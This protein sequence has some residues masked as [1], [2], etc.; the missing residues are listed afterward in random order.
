VLAWFWPQGAILTLIVA[1]AALAYGWGMSHDALEPYY[2]ASVRSMSSN[3]HDFLY[4]A[5]DPAGTLTL[6]KL[7][8][9][10]W[11]QA[12]FVAL[13]G[14]HTWAMVLPQAIEGVLTV[15]FLYRAVARLA[16]RSAGLVAA[17]VLAASPAVVALDRG[18]IGDSLMILLLVLAA[19][20]TSAA[21]VSG[22]SRSLV[23]AGVWV[24]LAFQAKMIQAWL[25]LPALALAYLISGPGA[26]S[27]RW[28]QVGVAG[29]V[30]GAV[31]VSWMA[32]VSVTP[33][34]Y[35]PYV[36]GSTNDSWFQQVF[37][38]NGLNRL[39]GE[40]PLQTLAGQNIGTS[41][42]TV[43][44][45]SPWRLLSGYL[46]LDT[47]W[48]LL[49]A[50]VVAAASFVALRRAPRMDPRRASLILWVSWLVVIGAAFS[51]GTSINP[52]YTAALAPAV[53]AIL[54]IGVGIAWSTRSRFVPLVAGVVVIVSVAYAVWLLPSMASRSPSWLRPAA[55][56]VGVAGLGLVAFAW[57]GR[58]RGILAAGLVASLVATCFAPTVAAVSIV[59]SHQ[60][61]FD[62]P[63]EPGSASAAI[64][65]SFIALP[66]SIA[67]TVPRLEQVRYGAP[68]LLATQTA[69]IAS[70]FIN[71]TGEEAL[72]IGGF[73]GTAP[74][75]TLADIKSDVCHGLFHLVLITD[76]S[77]PRFRWIADNCQLVGTDANGV[78]S[79]FCVPGA[80]C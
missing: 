49:A 13:F 75:P 30:T 7:P 65:N 58:R 69:V 3:A 46:G 77:D 4:G 22:R 23:L 26:A 62:T 31:S 78:E 15:V 24:G 21:V 36:D 39:G 5:V 54:G 60:G 9:A 79:Y 51:A 45:A 48:L 47:G 42:V 6:D 73:S 40:T 28:R 74:T 66:A 8:G 2:E 41:L 71:A 33:A 57:L 14:F 29:P 56:V 72:P 19:D 27:R 68:D 37:V 1:L 38:Y 55:I 63:F 53:A 32:L 61:A 64:D 10:L 12:I 11:V 35:G 18:N 43:A 80:E 16:G 50:V 20:A 59:A 44:P 52:Y 34:G 70:F 67:N 76:T 25:V 17:A